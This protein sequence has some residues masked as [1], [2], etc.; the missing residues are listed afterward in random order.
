[1]TDE[2]RRRAHQARKEYPETERAFE[3]VKSAMAVKLFETPL[4]ATAERER[5]YYSVQALV[6]VQKALMDAMGQ[7]QDAID[8]YIKSLAAT[9]AQ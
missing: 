5:L 1:M 6:A 7:G 9:E 8:D 2:E 4:S 3:R